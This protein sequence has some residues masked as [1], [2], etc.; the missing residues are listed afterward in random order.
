MEQKQ[1]K[2]RN[3]KIINS[4]LKLF[5]SLPPIPMMQ[6]SGH[7]DPRYVKLLLFCIKKG[8]KATESD[9]EKFFPMEE[10]MIY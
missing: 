6:C 5:G 9:I 8:R 4:Y 1:K 2:A 3:E 7:N 10:D